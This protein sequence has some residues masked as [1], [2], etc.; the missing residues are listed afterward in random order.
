MSLSCFRLKKSG[1][2][3]QKAIEDLRARNASFLNRLNGILKCDFDPESP[4]AQ[5]DICG[6]IN[7]REQNYEKSKET[8]QLNSDLLEENRALKEAHAVR[9]KEDEDKF[10]ESERQISDLREK[11]GKSEEAH[12]VR[13]KEYDDKLKEVERQNSR[14]LENYRKL[15]AY[16]AGL[17]ESCKNQR[18]AYEKLSQEMVQAGLDHEA[19]LASLQRVHFRA[20]QELDGGVKPM[21]DDS[22][23]SRFAALRDDVDDW[24][25]INFKL[26]SRMTSPKFPG[27]MEQTVRRLFSETAL[28]LGQ[29]SSPEILQAV[30]WNILET[31]VFQ[32]WLFGL[33][34]DLENSIKK[35]EDSLE[36]LSPAKT[37]EW[38]VYNIMRLRNSPKINQSKESRINEIVETTIGIISS[39]AEPREDR[40]SPET[41]LQMLRSIVSSAA[42]L[43]TEL[44]TQ[45]AVFEVD[46]RVEPDVAY[47][48]EAMVEI[49]F[50]EEPEELQARGAMVIC[51]LS[52]GWI[53]K[54]G[55][56]NVDD[57]CRIC[58]AKVKAV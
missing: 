51:V 30:F 15:E 48:P 18:I 42:E 41:R 45:K 23:A 14:L 29:I 13:L 3:A 37:Q 31:R 44:K 11:H 34:D 57:W 21:I 24:T 8:E 25:R 17:K 43:A 10:K 33:E 28:G 7:D 5:D 49:Q 2:K 46:Q 22:I 47:D 27:E 6:V 58:P 19:E 53:K 12:A 36:T 16:T 38:R 56:G 40:S 4:T 39:I 54:S 1:N 20:V 52:R 32:P 9:L 35:M 55:D 26:M 50:K